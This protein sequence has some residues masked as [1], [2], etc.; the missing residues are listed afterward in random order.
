MN[1]L[2]VYAIVSLCAFT[3]ESG[4]QTSHDY[5]N[6]GRRLWAA[7]ECAQWAHY[8]GRAE[9][10]TKLFKGGY[11]QG[12]AFIEALNAGKIEKS[13][14]ESEVPSTVRFWLQGPTPDFILGRIYEEAVEDV[15]NDHPPNSVSDVK[16]YAWKKFQAKNC[17]LL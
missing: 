6:M 5:A 12:K 7:F 3:T 14:L 4:A 17:S 11:E 8:A 10:E 13:D 15:N 16:N 2:G 9:V 1:R